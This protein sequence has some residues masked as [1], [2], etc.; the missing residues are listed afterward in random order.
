MTEDVALEK[1]KK[2]ARI[3]VADNCGELL[4]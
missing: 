3:F 2:D 1:V 4:L